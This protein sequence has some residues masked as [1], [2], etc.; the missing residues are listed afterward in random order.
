MARTASPWFWEERQG[1]YVNKDSQRRFLGDH[2]QDAPPPRKTKGKWNAPP[3]IVQAFHALMAAQPEPKAIPKKA[4]TPSTGIAT[5]SRVSSTACP[6]PRPC[7][8]LLS[9]RSTSSSGPTSIPTGATP[10][11]VAPCSPSSG[12]STA[13]R[14]WDTSPPARSRRRQLVAVVD[15]RPFACLD[16]LDVQEFVEEFSHQFAPRTC[17]AR[18]IGVLE[19]YLGGGHGWQIGLNPLSWHA[20]FPLLFSVSPLNYEACEGEFGGTGT[21]LD[22][23]LRDR[24]R[25]QCSFTLRRVSEQ[26]VPKLS[27]S[28]V[29]GRNGQGR[30]SL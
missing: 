3:P 29:E 28:R 26:T 16:L 8:W 18:P 20:K 6:V 4:A 21:F 10:T 23:W 2:P 30:K 13:P 22:S 27:G 14:S 24:G 11:A 9:G 25:T 1:W 15:V 12:P 5:I 19:L 7:P 17:R